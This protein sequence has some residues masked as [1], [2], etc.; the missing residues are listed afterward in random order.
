MIFIAIGSNLSHPELGPPRAVCEA[1]LERL[2]NCGVTVTR[3]SRWYSSAPVPASDQPWFVNGVAEVVPAS[4]RGPEELLSDLH[5]VEAAFGRTR[6][7]RNEARILDLDLL[8]FNGRVSTP[9]ASVQLPH[10]RLH[11]RSFVLLPLRE[12][13]PHWRHPATGEAINVLIARL[14]AHQETQLLD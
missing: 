5:S 11:R 9:G 6:E 2:Q 7:R 4:P 1:A 3:R 10:P 13:A 12:L 14:P 8:D